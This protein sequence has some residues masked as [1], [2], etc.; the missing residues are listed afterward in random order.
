M[1]KCCG[2]SAFISKLKVG[3]DEIPIIGLE[4]IMFLVFNMELVN[5]DEVLEA[6]ITE[7]EEMGN[8][9]P[10]NKTLEFNSVLMKEYK[11]FAEKI[12]SNRKKRIKVS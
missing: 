9:I 10:S 2:A 7:I 12:Q 1:K 3:D 4:P 5:D 11:L 6:L 8:E